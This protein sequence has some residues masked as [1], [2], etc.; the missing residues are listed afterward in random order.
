[1]ACHGIRVWITQG[2]EGCFIQQQL[3]HGGM[4]SLPSDTG[5]YG[6]CTPHQGTGAPPQA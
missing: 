6:V 4:D 2:E 5:V 1:M 3:P